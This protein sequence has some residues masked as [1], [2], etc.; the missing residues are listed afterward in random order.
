MDEQHKALLDALAQAILGFQD[1]IQE[2]NNPVY[3][4]AI[5]D[6]QKVFAYLYLL[7]S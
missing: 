6:L 5:V 4:E 1:A 2:E 3:A 7:G